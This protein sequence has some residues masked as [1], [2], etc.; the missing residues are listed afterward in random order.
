MSATKSNANTRTSAEQLIEL[1][2]QLPPEKQEFVNGYVQ[3]VSESVP[4]EENKSA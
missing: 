1:I 2:K 3:G 4:N